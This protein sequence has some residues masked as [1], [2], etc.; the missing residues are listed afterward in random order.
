MHDRMTDNDVLHRDCDVMLVGYEELENLGLRY[1]ASYLEQ[2][3]VRVRIEPYTNSDSAKEMLLSRIRDYRPAIVGFSMIFQRLLFEFEGLI[4]FLRNGGV[5]S[6][7]TMGGHF[8]TV[9][10]RATLENIAGLDSVVRCEGEETL[11][12][13]YRGFESGKSPE[14]IEGL[15]FRRNGNIVINGPRPLLENLDGLPFPRR[16]KEFLLLRDLP[17]CTIISSRGCYYNCSFCSIRQFYAETRGRKRRSRSPGNFVDEI[18]ML[19]REHGARIFIF[20]DDDFVMKTGKQHQWIDDFVTEV[21]KRGLGDKIAWRIS[22]RVD[23]LD[24][25]R[26][27]MMQEIGLIGVYL[28]V[29]SGHDEGLKVYNKHYK[30]EDVYRA[31]DKLHRLDIPYEF[32]FMIFNPYTTF[33]SLKKDIRFLKEIGEYGKAPFQFTKMVPYA[34]TPIARRLAEE[35]R[36]TGT[37][38]APD[39]DYEDPRLDLLQLFFSQAFHFRNFDNRGLVERLRFAKFDALIVKRFIS[40][41]YNADAYLQG[42]YGIIRECNEQ[43]T[44]TMSMAANFMEQLSEDGILERWSILESLLQTE[45]KEEREYGARLD[46]LMENYT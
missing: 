34:G 29:E 32:G 23:D 7:F 41:M 40:D 13:L 8:P 38:D 35:K 42:L 18:E 16:G 5:T 37:I 17:L 1:I 21:K 4:R 46:R 30:P 33:K 24:A 28:G 12:E 3:G 14:E 20:E 19:Y 2:Q 27:V 9:E 25:E 43:C 10:S 11:L 44:H 6:H 22:C 31:L 45:L 15:A 36:M 39:Y 26:L